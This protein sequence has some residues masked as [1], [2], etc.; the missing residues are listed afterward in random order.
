MP[1]AAA[2][3]RSDTNTVNVD[4][5]CT[6]K[7]RRQINSGDRAQTPGLHC[8]RINKPPFARW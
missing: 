3:V 4:P 7:L 6:L 5:E 2:I 8:D 1:I